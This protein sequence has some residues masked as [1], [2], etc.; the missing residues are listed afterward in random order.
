MATVSPEY[1]IPYVRLNLGDTDQATYRYTDT[2]LSLAIVGSI[3]ALGPWWRDR[4][5]IDTSNLIYRNSTEIFYFAEPPVIQSSDER[6]IVLMACLIIGE[7]SLE[8]NSWNI[9]SWRDNEISFTNLEQGRIKDSNLN[10]LRDE[11][12]YLLKP[13]TKRL[14][15][16]TK[17]SLPGYKNNEFENKDNIK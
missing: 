10:R 8:S 9:A 1:L 17:Q 12:L 4:Y 15:Y 11:L 13:P 5:L 2:W 16:S 6:P 3:K 7:G 14:A